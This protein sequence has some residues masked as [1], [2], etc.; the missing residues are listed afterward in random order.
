MTAPVR[1][2]RTLDVVD[3]LNPPDQIEFSRLSYQETKQELENTHVQITREREELGAPAEYKSEQDGQK[4][5]PK[6]NPGDILREI[7]PADLRVMVL[8][9]IER[10]K[11]LN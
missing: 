7:L 5:N 8:R 9:G 6:L 3:T 1:H 11:K 10:C 2:S 4:L